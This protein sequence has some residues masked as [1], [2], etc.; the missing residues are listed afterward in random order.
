MKSCSSFYFAS[1]EKNDNDVKEAKLMTKEPNPGRQ[2]WQPSTIS[3]VRWET[4]E[5]MSPDIH[6]RAL[7]NTGRLVPLSLYCC[8]FNPITFRDQ[9]I[10]KVIESRHWVFL[11][12][13]TLRY[14]IEKLVLWPKTGN[15]LLVWYRVTFQNINIPVYKF[16]S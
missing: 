14:L 2:R 11:K 6:L 7:F 1:T 10:A 9:V 12:S 16:H 15:K 4:T 8:W 13:L 5:I 3:G